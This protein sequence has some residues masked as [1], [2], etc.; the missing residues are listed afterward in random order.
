[1]NV[2]GFISFLPSTDI[3]RSAD[4]Y[5]RVLGLQLVLDQGG[6]RIYRLTDTAYLG[7]CQREPFEDVQP[8]ITTLLADDIDG[9]HAAIVATGWPDVTEPEH[10]DAYRIVHIWVTDP[11]GNK[12]EIQR[13]DDPDWN[14]VP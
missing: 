8:V 4:F 14:A 1:M 11:D 12:L 6:C 5:E 9:W 7:V 3:D 10:S 13:F 2:D